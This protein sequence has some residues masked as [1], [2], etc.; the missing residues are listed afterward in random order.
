VTRITV[1]NEL[2]DQYFNSRSLPICDPNN[3]LG[4]FPMIH[5]VAWPQLI[6]MTNQ[7]TN[8]QPRI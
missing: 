1:D 5:P 2:Q 7:S 3:P 4:N 6:C 8:Y